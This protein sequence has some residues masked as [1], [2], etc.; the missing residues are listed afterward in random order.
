MGVMCTWGCWAPG[1]APR[2]GICPEV[3]YTELEFNTATE[4]KQGPADF[5]AGH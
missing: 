5:H 2:C 4:A 3:S 1:M